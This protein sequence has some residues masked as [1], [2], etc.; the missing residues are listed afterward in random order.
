MTEQ[1]NTHTQDR[2]GPCPPNSNM[3]SRACRQ[4]NGSYNKGP[5]QGPISHTQPLGIS[6][7]P[8]TPETTPGPQAHIPLPANPR[9]G[10]WHLCPRPSWA[11]R[12]SEDEQAVSN[13]WLSF[14]TWPALGCCC[15]HS[16][17]PSKLICWSP[18]PQYLRVWLNLKTG[19]IQMQLTYSEVST[20]SSEKLSVSCLVVSNS[21]TPWTAACQA[22]LSM[23]FSR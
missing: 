11:T 5:A 9:R 21:M 13:R 7:T 12:A 6:P 22:P 23:E 1:L 19:P 2:N 17:I 4:R 3:P 14:R 15:K 8:T 20:I 18:N 16:Y 10:L